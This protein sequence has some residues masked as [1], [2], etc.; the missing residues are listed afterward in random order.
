M[1]LRAPQSQTAEARPISFLLDDQAAGTPPVSVTLVIRPEDLVRNDPSRM[2]VQQTLDGAWADNF[3][4]GITSIQ[5]SGT[6]G[7][8]RTQTTDELDGGERFAQLFDHVFTRWHQLQKDAAQAGRNPNLVQLVFADA[9]DGFALVVAPTNFVLRRSKSRP[10]L[11]QFQIALTVLS[12]H[13][14][15][16][17]AA[18]SSTSFIGPLGNSQATEQA[19]LASIS[20]S[21]AKLRD[22]ATSINNIV[23]RTML[24]PARDFLGKTARVYELTRQAISAGDS[25][26]ASLILFSRLTAQ[27]GINVFRTLAAAAGLPG[28]VRAQLM[29][30]GAA[31]SNVFCVLSNAVQQQQFY[32]DYNP[33]FGSSNCS[34]TN[35]GRP[36]SPLANQNP[37][38]SYTPQNLALPV[39]ALPTSTASMKAIASSDVVLAPMSSSAL[40]DALSTVTSG[41]AVT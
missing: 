27:S 18:H 30:I 33:L 5:I 15:P 19:G 24:A 36:L 11:C 8:R 22:Y 20:A 9:L 17:P 6:T 41:L 35:G 37:W 34:S 38:E 28:R 2:A 3:G 21:I 29:E 32:P 40:H 4:P 26:A 12:P 1:N 10:L 16:D 7:W 25:I 13:V 39:T 23:D 31:Y 14:D